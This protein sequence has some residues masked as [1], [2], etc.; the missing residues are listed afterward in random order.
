VVVIPRRESRLVVMIEV[1]VR[2][3]SDR[4]LVRADLQVP[5]ASK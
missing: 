4:E 5:I 3:C 1:L 2:R